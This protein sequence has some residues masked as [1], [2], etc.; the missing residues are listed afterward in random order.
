MKMQV[1]DGQGREICLKGNVHQIRVLENQPL[2]IKIFIVQ[3]SDGDDK[4]AEKNWLYSG[5]IVKI[6]CHFL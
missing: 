4:N 2:D 3:Q 6:K 1:Y 5:S